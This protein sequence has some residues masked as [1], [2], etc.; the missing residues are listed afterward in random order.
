[1]LNIRRAEPVSLSQG[2]Q[3]GVRINRLDGWLPVSREGKGSIVHDRSKVIGYALSS[4][5]GGGGYFKI[6]LCTCK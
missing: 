5:E 6:I 4:H 1:M 3:W 2:A